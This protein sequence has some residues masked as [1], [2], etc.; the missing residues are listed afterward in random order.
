MKGVGTGLRPKPPWNRSRKAPSSVYTKGERT[1]RTAAK[2]LEAPWTRGGVEVLG[3]YEN[4]GLR[5]YRLGQG[6]Q[7]ESYAMDVPITLGRCTE[8]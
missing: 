5:R 6:T 3:V 7:R 1:R 8:V 2:L 4:S